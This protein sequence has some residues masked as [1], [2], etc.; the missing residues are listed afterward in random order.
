[1]RKHITVWV[2]ATCANLG[3]GFDVLGVALP[4][5]NEIRMEADFDG[6]GQPHPQSLSLS[7]DVEGEGFDSL[8]RDES[9]LVVRAAY[10]LFEKAKRWPRW[11]NVKMTNRIPLSRG[12]GSSAAATLGG[13]CA[14]NRLCGRP[15]SDQDILDLG[16]AIEGHPD[17]LVPALVGGFCICGAIQQ[18]THYLRF[19]VPRSLHAVVCVPNKPLSTPKARRILPSRIPLSAAVFTSSRV[20]FLIGSILQKRYEWLTFAMDDVLHQPPRAAMLPGLKEVIEEAKQAGAYGAALS[21]AGSSV[22]AF[23]KPGRTAK[24]VGQAMQKKFAARGLA[25][26]WFETSLEN[27]GL[28]YK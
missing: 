13:L 26:R 8:P 5:F 14:A 21:G 3:P 11:L 19:R 20:A 22:I 2:P 15:L 25:S 17:N 16:M 18:K 23:C 7:V 27:K 4:L 12:L 6:A 1:M 9:N 10:F 28:R 24:Q